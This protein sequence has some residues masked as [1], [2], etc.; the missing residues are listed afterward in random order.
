[1]WCGYVC[2]S[3]W[4]RDKWSDFPLEVCNEA[5]DRQSLRLTSPTSPPSRHFPDGDTRL[6]VGGSK[7]LNPSFDV[8]SPGVDFSQVLQCLVSVIMMYFSCIC[9]GH[10]TSLAC[11]CTLSEVI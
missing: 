6:T 5:L 2:N 11:G 1:M 7:D 10:S 4:S 8:T 9:S 3:E